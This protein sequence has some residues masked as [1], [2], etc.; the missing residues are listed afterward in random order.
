M[1]NKKV[2]NIIAIVPARKGSVRVKNKNLKNFN[3]KPLI[4][5]TLKNIINSKFINKS[6]ISSD[7]NKILNYCK[8]IFIDIFL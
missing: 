2:K 4:Y 1:I 6:I 5:W 8:S 3:N 7:S